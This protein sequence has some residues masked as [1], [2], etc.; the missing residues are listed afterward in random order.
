M[1]YTAHDFRL[2][3]ANNQSGGGT[4]GSYAR[5]HDIRFLDTFPVRPRIG[6]DDGTMLKFKSRKE[7]IQFIEKHDFGVKAFYDNK[8]YTYEHYM[9]SNYLVPSKA[10][11]LTC[12]ARLEPGRTCLGI[13]TARFAGM[14]YKNATADLH[15]VRYDLTESVIE[16]TYNR[17]Q[18]FLRT[19]HKENLFYGDVKP[20]NLLI[21]GKDVVVG[22]YGS[23]RCP[24]DA[25][26][27]YSY[28]RT[29][30]APSSSGYLEY[31]TSLTGSGF[32]MGT[33]DAVSMSKHKQAVYNFN[34][35]DSEEARDWYHFGIAIIEMIQ[36]S[37]C[38]SILGAIP[39]KRAA[40]RINAIFDAF[41]LYPK[42]DD[43]I[44]RFIGK[45]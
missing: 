15:D 13:R 12:L 38:C 21:L 2:A 17:V 5:N 8:G 1:L 3:F 29:Y 4:Y 37:E 18:R 16:K 40:A 44:V 7:F 28:V 26:D 14:V 27:V 11:S 43:R 35:S 42:M 23:L 39:R 36:A 32:E 20:P 34:G 45:M 6:L 19:I 10:T 41:C 9:V 31:W 22:D 24:D 30:P 33:L 25:N